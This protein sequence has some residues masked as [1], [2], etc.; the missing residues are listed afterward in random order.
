MFVIIIQQASTATT[1]K[2]FE[3]NFF[4][5]LWKNRLQNLFK[6]FFQLICKRKLK[7]I[8]DSIMIELLI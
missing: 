3:F 8:I 1:T 5:N 2:I 7:L 6:I 4:D